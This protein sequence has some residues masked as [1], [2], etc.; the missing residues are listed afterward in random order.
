MTASHSDPSFEAPD[1]TYKPEIGNIPYDPSTA[2][3]VTPNKRRIDTFKTYLDAVDDITD[4]LIADTEE[5]L[6]SYSLTIDDDRLWAAQSAE[7]PSDEIP[8]TSKSIH[9]RQ[10]KALTNR[11][12]RGADY[13]KTAYE[14]A[15]RGVHG[16]NSLDILSMAVAIK[17]EVSNIRKFLKNYL[18]SDDESAHLETVNKLQQW[19]ENALYFS[20]VLR[21]IFQAGK[22]YDE[23]PAAEVEQITPEEAVKFQALFQ[24]KLNSF[25]VD[26]TKQLQTINKDFVQLSGTYYNELLGPALDFRNKVGLSLEGFA[27]KG[28]LGEHAAFTGHSLDLN[29][30]MLLADQVQRGE[31]FRNSMNA[32]LNYMTQRDK[33]VSYINQL[34][35]VGKRLSSP[36][37]EEELDGD[38]RGVFAEM[39]NRMESVPTEL[40]FSSQHDA[41]SGAETSIHPQHIL[42]SGDIL[43]GELNF[44]EGAVIDGIRPSTHAHTGEDGSTKIHGTSILAGSVSDEVVDTSQQP[45]QPSTLQ[46]LSKDAKITTPG[47]PSF[48]ILISWDGDDSL[49]YDVSIV[50]DVP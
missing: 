18:E 7:W 38:T 40:L 24:I 20:R 3:F 50:E 26:L 11:S 13:I 30:T 14:R 43:E 29:L 33:Y 37:S 41:L 28:V 10:Y 21:N 27:K 6:D 35:S 46:I 17:I 48:D 42:K 15:I 32:A 45:A 12:T 4:I 9:Y 36:F 2:S 49:I 31:N 47:I 34:S 5:D 8:E 39:F 16:S 22:H 19:A 1:L 44:A 25:N 23:I